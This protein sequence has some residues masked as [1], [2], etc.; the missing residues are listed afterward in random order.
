MEIVIGTI[1]ICIAIIFNCWSLWSTKKAQQQNVNVQL[2]KERY[3]VYLTLKNWYDEVYAIVKSPEGKLMIFRLG[4]RKYTETEQKDSGDKNDLEKC[5]EIVKKMQDE[6][7]MAIYLFSLDETDIREIKKIAAPFDITENAVN[8]ELSTQEPVKRM[9][10]V[11]TPRYA[12]NTELDCVAKILKTM[13]YQ[14]GEL[15]R[16]FCE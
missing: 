5:K 7:N 3:N 15:R 16:S 14:L 8:F 11:F 13:E 10:A 4:M 12:I 6:I 1:G 2:F 9:Y